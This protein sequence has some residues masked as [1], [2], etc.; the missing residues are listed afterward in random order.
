M[1]RIDYWQYLIDQ[2]GRPLQNAQVRVY[3]AGSTTEANI[4]LNASFGAFTTSSVEDFKTNKYGFFQF[5]VGDEWETNGGYDATQ[6][7][8]I[9]WQ[10]DVDGIQEEIDDICIYAPV[11]SIDVTDDIKGVPSNKDKNKLISNNQGYK[12]NT[13]VDSIVP[14]ASPHNLQPVVFFDLDTIQNKIISDKIGYQMYEMAL[15]ASSI[16]VDVSAAN[17]YHTTISSWTASGGLYYTDIAHNFNNYYPIVKVIKTSNDRDMEIE[18][19]KSI[20]SNVT[21]IW[22]TENISASAIFFG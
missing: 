5:W 7:F 22:L 8:K 1:A 11:L 6:K 16:S 19:L 3:L 20:N 17:F 10:N 14:S 9:V 12:W 18:S 2:Q 21:R 4:Y 15:T 13:H